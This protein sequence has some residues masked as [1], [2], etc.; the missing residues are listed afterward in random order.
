MSTARWRGGRCWIAAIKASSIVSR[1]HND[2]A[3]LLLGRRDLF[4]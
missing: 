1:A 2:R 4:E 3:R